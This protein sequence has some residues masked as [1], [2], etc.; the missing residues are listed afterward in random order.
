V[1]IPEGAIIGVSA[2]PDGQRFVTV[3]WD[4]HELLVFEQDLAE[5]ATKCDA[6]QET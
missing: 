4:Q 1:T 5:R 6:D 3:Q 2:H